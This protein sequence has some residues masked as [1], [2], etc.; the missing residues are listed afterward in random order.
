VKPYEYRT[1]SGAIGNKRT[2]PIGTPV[3]VTWRN[4]STLETRTASVPRMF[5]SGAWGVRVTGAATSVD[6]DRVRPRFQDGLFPT[7]ADSAPQSDSDP[8]KA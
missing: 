3:V 6:L 8:P 4:G 5:G 2:W 7:D 1:P